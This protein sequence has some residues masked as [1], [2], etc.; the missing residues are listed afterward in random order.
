[1]KTIFAAAPLGMI[2]FLNYGQWEVLTLFVAAL[3]PAEM[4][5]WAIM[6]YLWSILKYISD[7]FADAAEG[8]VALHLVLNNPRDARRSSGK[9]HFLGFFSSSFVTSILFLIGMELAKAMSPD[10]TLQRL[11]I[12]IFPL[13]GIGNVVQATASISLSILGA[14]ERAGYAI[15][16]QIMGNWGVTMILGT[17]FTFGF[18][19]DLQGLTSAFVLG[20]GLSSSGVTYLLL[21]SVWD[22]L[23]SRF[24]HRY[25]GEQATDDDHP[26]SN[27]NK[28]ST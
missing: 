25:L 26:Q 23:A 13:I 18:Q 10:P 8:R 2:Y 7:G 3:G 24:H 6:G 27:A 20:L 28:V 19:I 21:R 11:M 4:V 17:V 14:Q 22:T 15:L 1:M 5:A 12:E 16:V 9:A